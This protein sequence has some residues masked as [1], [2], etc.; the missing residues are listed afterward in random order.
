M[1]DRP[2]F[3]P[4]ESCSASQRYAR[5]RWFR[6]HAPI[7]RGCSPFPGLPDAV[8]L[9]SHETVRM[10][11]THRAILQAPDTEEYRITRRSLMSDPV[12]GLLL[13]AV[14]FTDPPAH[15]TLRRPMTRAMTA[16]AAAQREASLRTRA[17]ALVH[18][19][20]NR[21]HFDLVTDFA[22]PYI[23]G[24][25]GEL[26]GLTLTDIPALKRQT[27]EMARALD[28]RACEA[29]PAR[30]ASSAPELAQW[31]ECALDTTLVS[32]EGLCATFL[33]HCDSGQWTRSDVIT[34]MVFL[35]FAGQET[36]VDALGNA[37]LAIARHPGCWNAVTTGAV[38]SLDAV[39][40]L[41]R[42]DPS[43]QFASTRVSA[44]P[45]ELTGAVIPAGIPIVAVL[46]SANRD[47]AVFDEP[48]KLR[49]DRRP[50]PG[51]TFG[52]GIHRC[53][54]AHIARVEIAIALETL[55]QRLPVW[56]VDEDSV[57]ER[58]AITFRG[59]TSI[60]VTLHSAGAER[61]PVSR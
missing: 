11:L 1:N 57:I 56:R 59:H 16:T 2:W 5:Y 18:A 31:V 40:E 3:D 52:H 36:A 45:V 41:L 32:D 42:Y 38:T 29:R 28:F 4:F 48:D 33:A 24:A 20:E 7:A 34:N 10:C 8:Y 6:E 44:K 53:A 21:G 51:M 54:G 35:L 9:F 39:D 23:V 58:D 43:L 25:I 55:M 13:K 49:L 12:F 19:F 27:A 47:P 14:L 50:G 22:T 60:P 15:G 37:V 30:D 61:V 17:E 26:L 46:A